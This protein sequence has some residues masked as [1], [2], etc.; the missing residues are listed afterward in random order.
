[1]SFESD[2]NRSNNF[3]FFL[4][5]Y[6]Y[7]IYANVYIFTKSFNLLNFNRKYMY[8]QFISNLKIISACGVWLVQND[9]IYHFGII[10]LWLHHHTN[11]RWLA[12]RQI[13]WKTGVWYWNAY[14]IHLH[15]CISGMRTHFGK[16][17][18]CF[19]SSSWIINGKKKICKSKQI[20]QNHKINY[21]FPN[22]QK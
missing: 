12:G 4:I 9:P 17:G 19:A 18:V 7:N 15:T 20:Y 16:L 14:C 1:M 13:R 3:I 6:M 5:K 21:F 2:M 22:P 8:H 11:P 10:F